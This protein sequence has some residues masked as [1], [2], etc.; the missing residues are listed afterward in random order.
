MPKKARTQP[1][2]VTTTLDA[3]LQTFRDWVAQGDDAAL[4][5]YQAILDE[6]VRKRR[7][8]ELD[9]V[10]ESFKTLSLEDQQRFLNSLQ[11]ASKKKAGIWGAEKPK[12]EKNPF[13]MYQDYSPDENSQYKVA[14]LVNVELQEIFTGGNPQN[15]GWLADLSSEERYAQ[16][17]TM[18]KLEQDP[19]FLETLMTVPKAVFKPE[20]EH[21]VDCYSG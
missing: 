20:G 11:S 9:Q 2:E 1:Y 17:G 14:P 6:E 21:W 15:K 7:D 5:A 19:D 10:M 3:E 4:A 12:K 16:F 13:R 8:Q 18:P